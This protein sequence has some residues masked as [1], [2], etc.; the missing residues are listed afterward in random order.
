MSGTF[1]AIFGLLGS[2]KWI[3]REGRNGTSRGGIG[4]PMAMGLKKSLALR[5]S[6]LL[7]VYS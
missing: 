2:K 4:A 6:W 5:M 7:P 1:D 3:I